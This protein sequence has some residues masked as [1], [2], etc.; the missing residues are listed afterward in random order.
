MERLN[1]RIWDSIV[2]TAQETELYRFD[3][4]LQD[5]ILAKQPWAADVHYFKRVKISAVALVK[6]VMH[7]I[8]GGNIE[9]MGL[10]QGKV[11]GNEIIVLDAFGLPVEGTETRVNAHAAANE[12]MVQY[13]TSGEVVG[14]REGTCG[15][16]HSH[17]GYGC[18]L[19]GIDVSTERIHQQVEDPYVAIVIDPIKTLSSGKV[20]L[21]C[22]RTYPEDRVPE[23]NSASEYQHI[24]LNKIED[25][26]VHYKCYY[27][28]EYTI[29]KSSMDGF[30]L[31]CLWNKYWTH[32]LSSSTLLKN[33]DYSAG[34][35]MDIAQK[36]EQMDRGSV[37]MI[38]PMG[39]SKDEK[40]MRK[41]ANDAAGVGLE[42]AQGI[43]NLMMKNMLFYQAGEK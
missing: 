35:V 20:E 14:K 43:M 9:I 42:Q 27:K 3:E 17:P 7:A 41:V 37:R 33:K 1:Q 22:F 13:V 39:S 11:L 24:P 6:M 16:Y 18:W 40:E 26:G 25:F 28:L 5:S 30:V 29:F 15:W 23:S 2:L 12:Y 38:S 4:D 34:L 10:I 31:D 8:S 36:I 19:S 32:T 21:G